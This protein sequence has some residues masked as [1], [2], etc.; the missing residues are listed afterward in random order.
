MKR[1]ES[2]EFLEELRKLKLSSDKNLT[3]TQISFLEKGYNFKECY[4][5]SVDAS[6]AYNTG[7]ALFF[8]SAGINEIT[9]SSITTTNHRFRSFYT[10]FQAHLNYLN[11]HYEPYRKRLEIFEKES[12][13]IEGLGEG[14]DKYYEEHIDYSKEDLEILEERT[15]KICYEYTYGALIALKLFDSYRK[16]LPSG[17]SVRPGFDLYF[18]TVLSSQIKEQKEKLE[19]ILEE[20]KEFAIKKENYEMAAVIKNI[21]KKLEGY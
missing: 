21:C 9:V 4:P 1:K 5:K 14:L 2:K 17:F 19:G 15:R 7:L 20:Q 8:K 13:E 6:K 3:S 18:D 10:I 12:K 11:K 16:K